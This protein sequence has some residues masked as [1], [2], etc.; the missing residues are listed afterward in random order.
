MVHGDSRVKI[1]STANNGDSDYTFGTEE[2]WPLTGS[3]HAEDPLCDGLWWGLHILSHS[4]MSYCNRDHVL[5][6]VFKNQCQLGI[7]QC[8]KKLCISL[9]S[10]SRLSEELACR[11][12]WGRTWGITKLPMPGCF[13]V[14]LMRT[15][16][17]QLM[18]SD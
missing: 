13:W 10:V 18:S 15:Q 8:S 4:H 3:V 11:S 7:Q 1:L 16:L 12:L 14:L 9:L 2:I 6:W 17:L 5:L